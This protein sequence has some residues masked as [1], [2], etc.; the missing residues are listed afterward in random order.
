MPQQSKYSNEQFEALM[1]D[2]IAVLEKHQANRDFSLMVLGNVITNIFEHQVSPE[3]R[4]EL[5]KKFTDV[6][7]K[8]IK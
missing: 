4:E 6:L 8:S 1:S 2:I 7:L 5:A 3:Q